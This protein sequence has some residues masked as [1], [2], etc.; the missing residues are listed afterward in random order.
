MVNDLFVGE[1][2]TG[3]KLVYVN[4]VIKGKL[5]ECEVLI[6]Q[7]VNNTQGAVC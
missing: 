2:T 5:L 6:E 1:L 7:A 3:D 4:D